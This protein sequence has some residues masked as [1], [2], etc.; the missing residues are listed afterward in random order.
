MTTITS[1]SH[2]TSLSFSLQLSLYGA[3]TKT[4][5]PSTELNLKITSRGEEGGCGWPGVISLTQTQT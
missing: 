2:Y 4:N 3:V 5:Y 1:K